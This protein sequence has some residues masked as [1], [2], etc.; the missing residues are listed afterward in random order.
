MKVRDIARCAVM[1]A[2]LIAVQY[3]L[4]FVAGVELVTAVFAAYCYVSGAR[5]GLLTGAAFSLLRCLIF[6]FMPNV[7]ILYLIYYSVFA[8]VISGIPKIHLPKWL[9]PL[10]LAALCMASAFFA[11]K[12]IPVSV[13]YKQRVKT[14]LWIL[15]AVLAALTVFGIFI[16]LKHFRKR[17]SIIKLYEV[18]AA[19]SALTVMFTLLDDVITPL[20][21]GY[22]KQTAAAYFY[23]SFLAMLPQTI[24]AAV[25]VFVT[26]LPL[27]RAFEATK[28]Q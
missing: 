20:F 4:S 13:M 18:T 10:I 22:S 16:V 14:F 19:A 8:L 5:S 28:N 7:I 17:D 1:T 2:L 27:K 23:G 6:G 26:F 25:S 15:A 21:Y 3:A 11:V 12:G 24:C 9:S